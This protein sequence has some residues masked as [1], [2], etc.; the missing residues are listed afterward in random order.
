MFANQDMSFNQTV[1]ANL[2][3]MIPTVALVK[4]PTIV[5]TAKTTIFPITAPAYLAIPFSTA[6]TLVPIVLPVPVATL[7]TFSKKTALAN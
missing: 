6:A 1:L 7:I 5:L 4:A 2:S 3:A